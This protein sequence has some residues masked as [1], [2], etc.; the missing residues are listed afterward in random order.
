MASP[1]I[2]HEGIALLAPQYFGSIAWYAALA[3]HSHAVI[4]CGM[5]FDKRMKT[6][7]RCS[8]AGND[9]PLAL[10]V[11][12]SK[13]VSMTRARWHDIEVSRH[14]QWWHVHRTALESAYGRT[15]YFEFYIDR[16]KPWLEC[17]SNTDNTSVRLTDMVLAL[18]E[19]IR[20]DRLLPTG[21]MT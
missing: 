17:W 6:V 4:D 1:L 20:A 10:T 5:R 13:P 8:I 11:P 14:G 2:R 18:D 7:H 19:K 3:S 15:P 12:I 21:V 16:F 9:G